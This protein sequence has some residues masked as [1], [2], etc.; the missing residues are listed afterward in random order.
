[1]LGRSGSS[2]MRFL[3]GA[4]VTIHTNPQTV[5]INVRDKTTNKIDKVQLLDYIASTCP[6]LVG[7]YTK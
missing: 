1:L 7:Y 6:S 3:F 5:D 4:P 2:E